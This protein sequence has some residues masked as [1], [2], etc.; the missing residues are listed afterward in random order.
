MNETK[1]TCEICKQWIGRLPN[2]IGNT[3]KSQAI[4]RNADWLKIYCH[5]R[6]GMKGRQIWYC[7]GCAKKTTVKQ[8]VDSV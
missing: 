4:A 8:M 7:P 2:V 6:N 5:S 1:V 3:L